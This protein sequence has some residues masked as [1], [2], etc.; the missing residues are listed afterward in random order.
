[1]FDNLSDDAS[2]VCRGAWGKS[3]IAIDQLL[4]LKK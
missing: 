2:D 4:Q 3:S 1:M